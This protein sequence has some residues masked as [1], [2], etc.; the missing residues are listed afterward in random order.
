MIRPYDAWTFDDLKPRP[1]D[2]W[3]FDRYDMRATLSEISKYK[4]IWRVEHSDGLAI[5]GVKPLY[6]SLGV[7]ESF[8][9][10][11]AAMFQKH[12]RQFIR[13]LSILD[14]HVFKKGFWRLQTVGPVTD[15]QD[16]WM[17]FLG[18]TK[19]GIMRAY[20]ETKEDCAMFAKVV[21]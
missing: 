10:P 11:N 1:E 14:E 16:R 9:L 5:V 17:K 6:E 2:Q 4:F 3:L 20:L 18:Y 19:E 15:M 13:S 8:I 7:G 21:I 12:K